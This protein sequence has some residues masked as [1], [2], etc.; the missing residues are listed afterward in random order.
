[1]SFSACGAAR[2]LTASE[3]VG[4]IKRLRGWQRRERLDA[5]LII[6]EVNRHYF[7]G[8]KASNGMLLS[9]LP[10]APVFYTDFRYLLAARKRL[11]FMEVGS[12]WRPADE[13]AVLAEFGRAWRRV[14]YEG[15]MPAA[16]FLAWREALPHVEWVNLDQGVAG[17]RAVKSRAEQT[18]IRAAVKA[19]DAALACV[20]R[21]V[22]TGMSEWDIGGLV[23]HAAETLGQGEAFETV[24]C[25]G[26][27]AA[28][29]H[30]QPGNS[31]L[32]PGQA[33]L[34][35]MGVLRDYYCSDLTRTV[36]VGAA[37]SSDLANI[38]RVV[39]DANQKAIRAIRPGRRCCDI[40]AVAR[41]AIERAG[42]GEYFGHSLGHGLG[43]E[44]HE[45]PSFSTACRT[46]LE[47][48]M[49]LTVEPG[50]Y[51]PGRFGVRIEDVVLITEGGCEV[52]SQSPRA[53][54]I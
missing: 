8:L 37:P 33:L 22:R 19:N 2:D 3:F 35:D 44:V 43:L 52:L 45:A 21:Q 51:L 34:I 6:S 7:T 48:G 42:Y 40:D 16:R 15:Q 39:L 18:L 23:R 54:R 25:V 5:L 38:Y 41:R 14:G 24:V 9:E 12:I 30:H 11:T 20:L 27:N 53:L 29:C 28:E 17:L 49:V 31:R 46:V 10:G 32:R 4:R 26:R 47:P 50:I 36:C 13:A 1:M